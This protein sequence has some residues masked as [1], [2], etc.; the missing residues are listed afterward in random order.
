MLIAIWTCAVCA[1]YRHG[2]MYANCFLQLCAA[3]MVGPVTGLSVQECKERFSWMVALAT[4]HR[5]RKERGRPPFKSQ[6]M[7]NWTKATGMVSIL[8]QCFDAAN[9]TLWAG[10]LL[11]GA[12]GPRVRVV[13]SDKWETPLNLDLKPSTNLSVVGPPC[14]H[15]IVSNRDGTFGTA[16]SGRWCAVVK[17]EDLFG[18][19]EHNLRVCLVHG[20]KIAA[21]NILAK[22]EQVGKWA[23]IQGDAECLNCAYGRALRHG[24]EY[25][26][27]C[28][29]AAPEN[30]VIL[31][32]ES[33]E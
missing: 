22:L 24:F 6:E 13:A 17:E 20:N 28:P 31:R 27:D 2:V 32:S 12:D 16:C 15:P 10:R 5:A 14:Q 19:G 18:Q 23:Y 21:Q 1:S 26:I 29:N 11:T 7:G 3:A 30:S 4:Y 33:K 9:G 25:V 8:S